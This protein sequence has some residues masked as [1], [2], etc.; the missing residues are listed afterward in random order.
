MVPLWFLFSINCYF[1]SWVAF[2]SFLVRV[3]AFAEIIGYLAVVLF[4]KSCFFTSLMCCNFCCDAFIAGLAEAGENRQNYLR[5]TARCSHS[6]G[7]LPAAFPVHASQRWSLLGRA[8][9]A[10]A[11][12]LGSRGKTARSPG[13]QMVFQAELKYPLS[14]LRVLVGIVKGNIYDISVFL[15]SGAFLFQG[16]YPR[17]GA[18]GRVS[19]RVSLHTTAGSFIKDVLPGVEGGGGK[20]SQTVPSHLWESFEC[21]I[22]TESLRRRETELGNTAG[23]LQRSHFEA[24]IFLFHIMKTSQQHLLL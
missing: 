23:E 1:T 16:P 2:L 14:F 17:S 20:F 7:N 8:R 4:F 15:Q 5:A 12:V 3:L 18:R 6:Q 21:R 22:V 19:F 13:V 10:H 11:Q 9:G 24:C